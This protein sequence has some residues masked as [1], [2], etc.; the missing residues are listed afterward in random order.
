MYP[1][2]IHDVGKA[3]LAE[4]HEQAQRDALAHAVRAARRARQRQRGQRAPGLLTAVTR[5]ARRP[6]PA[7]ECS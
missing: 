1:T 4:M 2:T 3:R 6:E 7:E 5:W